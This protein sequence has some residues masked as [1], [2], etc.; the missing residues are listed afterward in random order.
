MPLLTELGAPFP[1]APEL[2]GDP[3]SV[4]PVPDSG[5]HDRGPYDP[6]DAIVFTASQLDQV[7]WVSPVLEPGDATSDPEVGIQRAKVCGVF[8]AYLCYSLDAHQEHTLGDRWV[9]I[10]DLIR[11]AGNLWLPG[12]QPFSAQMRPYLH[13]Q[14]HSAPF[15]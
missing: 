7:S 9:T 8:T 11:R 10:V 2:V 12:Q 3:L 4:P 15:P 1:P 6:E 5:P 13:Q 14:H